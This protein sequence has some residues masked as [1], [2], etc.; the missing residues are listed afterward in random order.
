M[1][2]SITTFVLSLAL[3]VTSITALEPGE[4]PVNVAVRSV[5]G[6]LEHFYEKDAIEYYR[7]RAEVAEAELAKRQD[8]ESDLYSVSNDGS[9]LKA[10]SGAGN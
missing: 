1:R 8:P 5:N 4:V 7:K 2:F 9:G 6:K 3:M 10:F